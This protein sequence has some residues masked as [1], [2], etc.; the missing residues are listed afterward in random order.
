[1]HQELD[2]LPHTSRGS[3]PWCLKMHC[4]ICLLINSPSEYLGAPLDGSAFPFQ[5]ITPAL[6][7]QKITKLDCPWWPQNLFRSP[8]PRK[9]SPNLRIATTSCIFP[10]SDVAPG[11]INTF[12]LHGPRRARLLCVTHRIFCRL[13]L[14]CLRVIWY[15]FADHGGKCWTVSSLVAGAVGLCSHQFPARQVTQLVPPGWTVATQIIDY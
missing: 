10:A 1:M 3:S 11:F 13:S 5:R 7:P 9:S 2:K 6:F 12:W 15:L 8:L 14:C 4:F